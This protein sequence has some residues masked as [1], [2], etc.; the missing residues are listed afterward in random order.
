MDAS[1]FS[2]FKD[3]STSIG[4]IGNL[5]CI[6]LDQTGKLSYDLFV[7]SKTNKQQT[8]FFLANIKMMQ[9]YTLK[10]IAPLIGYT[11]KGTRMKGVYTKTMKR[12]REVEK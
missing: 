1:V 3:L 6:L 7:A 11:E 12:Y 4:K 9:Y 8:T 5:D 2:Y 10:E